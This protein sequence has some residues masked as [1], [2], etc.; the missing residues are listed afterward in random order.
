MSE[1][2][3]ESEC[4][5]RARDTDYAGF[6]RPSALLLEMQEA[7]GTHAELL[8]AG[9]EAMRADNLAW[10]LSRSNIEM[11][12]CPKLGETIRLRTWPAKMRH[13]IFP[14]YFEF[15]TPDG[16][17]LGR[18]STAWVI[19]DIGARKMTATPEEARV[20]IAENNDRPAPLPMP[21][22]PRMLD[23]PVVTCTRIAAYADVDINGHVNNTRYIDWLCD[24]LPYETFASRG[25]QTLGIG[26]DSEITPG[27]PVELAL[28][29]DGDRFS[30]RGTVAGRSCFTAAGTLAPR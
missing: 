10:V 6:L 4:T 27:E 30:L 22:A 13:M 15:E 8:G 19:M 21:R 14:R 3:F 16:A 2:L 9:F 26:Y 18:A 28:A 25:I 7:A 23:A 11:D 12:R 29:L 5:L 17:P 24:A 1:I 20:A